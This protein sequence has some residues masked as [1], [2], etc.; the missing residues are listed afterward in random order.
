MGNCCYLHVWAGLET[1]TWTGIYGVGSLCFNFLVFLAQD[2]GRVWGT[3]M[4]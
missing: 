1:G 3:I 4:A 2:K